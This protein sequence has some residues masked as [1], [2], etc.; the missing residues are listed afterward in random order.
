[1]YWDFV[2]IS[3]ANGHEQTVLSKPSGRPLTSIHLN[4]NGEYREY[5]NIDS[6]KIVNLGKIAGDVIYDSTWEPLLNDSINIHS[7][8]FHIS[9]L[10]KDSLMLK[11][12]EEYIEKYVKSKYQDK[13]I[14]KTI[15]C[16]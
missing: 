2:Y 4:P 15:N 13:I 5:L 9:K 3:P 16:K 10:T 12:S 7:R 14:C 6:I 8:N 1:M 11:Y